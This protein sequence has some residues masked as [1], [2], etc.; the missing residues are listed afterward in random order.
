MKTIFVKRV[1]LL[2]IIVF[3]A[4]SASMTVSA[5]SINE[6][7]EY[8]YDEI[9]IPKI[10]ENYQFDNVELDVYYDEIYEHFS[11]Q[12]LSTIAQSTPDYILIYCST[13]IGYP[14]SFADLFGDYVLSTN[15]GGYPFVFNYGIYVPKTEE[16]YSLSYA[17]EIE[18]EGIEE[19]FTEAKIG[20]LIG[21]MDK[22][23][24]ITIKDATY[25]QK[26]LAGILEFDKY[27]Y[28]TAYEYE[29]NP[30][31]LYVSD[32]NRD[33]ERN[34]KDATAIQKHLAKMDY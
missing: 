7:N 16:I 29:E 13:N 31:L 25:L 26:C 18:L 19:V 3:F 20:R 1:S 8:K 17:Y 21:D 10:L 4:F 33:C 30:P 22:D 34:I 32:F 2:L 5:I 28:I 15:S 24:K 27:D 6:E 9:I 11:N 14:S 12:T 23:R